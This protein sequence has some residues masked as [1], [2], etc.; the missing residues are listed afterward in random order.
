MRQALRSTRL[1]SLLVYLTLIAVVFATALGAGFVFAHEPQRETVTI[2]VR[3]S[4][5]AP[6][7]SHIVA[8]VIDEIRDGA[9]VIVGEEQS[10]VIDIPAGVAIDELTRVASGGA[11]FAPG[12][13]VNLGTA[14]TQ[15]GFIVTGI[16]AVAGATP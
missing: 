14:D 9:I 8:G 10:T 2:N 6:P 13:A 3:Q 11:P 12:T 7:P 16:V 15:T 1:R 5:L 4:P